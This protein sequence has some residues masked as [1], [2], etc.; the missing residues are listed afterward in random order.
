MT[1]FNK[2]MIM[3]LKQSGKLTEVG[4][5]KGKGNSRVG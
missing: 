4:M 2:E 3:A 1:L 5:R